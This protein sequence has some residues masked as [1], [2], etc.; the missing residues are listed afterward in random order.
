LIEFLDEYISQRKRKKQ[1]DGRSITSRS[2]NNYESL[3]KL[4][5][6]F[7]DTGFDMDIISTR[8][9]NMAMIRKQKKQWAKFYVEF[10]DYLYKLG[11]FDNYVG[12]NI[13]LLKAFCKWLDLDKGIM[14]GP[15]YR[16]FRVIKE[17]IAIVVL[18][19]EQLQFLITNQPFDYGLQ[20]GMK[21]IKDLFVFGCTV[22]LRVSDLILL[23]SSNLEIINDAWYLKVYAKKT[24]VFT[25]IKLPAYAIEIIKRNKS[26]SAYLFS[27]TRSLNL[28]KKFKELAELAG[29]TH[30]VVKI[31]MR[32]GKPIIIYKEMVKRIHYRFCDLITTHTMRRTAITT[33]LSLG[34]DELSVRKISGHAPGSTE[35][36]KYVQYHQQNLDEKTDMV[37]EKLQQ[38]S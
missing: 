16:H 37:F 18:N 11:H 19:P 2:L 10:T 30:Q 29:W 22:G 7:Q 13:K 12:M 1:L 33:M 6:N 38:L 27:E 36:Y 8:T 23:K 34:M 32:K 14:I 4:L 5:R 20:K 28:N 35:F 17:S 21:K 3:A 24:H 9:S 15:Y 26:K 25:K 31:R